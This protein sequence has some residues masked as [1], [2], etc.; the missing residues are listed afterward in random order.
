MFCSNCGAQIPDGSKF[1]GECGA[2]IENEPIAQQQSAQSETEIQP[3]PQTQPGTQIQPDLQPVQSLPTQQ[4]MGQPAPKK[5]MP[6]WAKV[7]IGVGIGIVALFI[8]FIVLIFVLASFA[9]DKKATDSKAENTTVEA[10]SAPEAQKEEEK[11]EETVPEQNTDEAEDKPLYGDPGIEEQVIYDEGGVKVTATGFSADKATGH[12]LIDIKLE[13]NSGQELLITN[14][15]TR[16]NGIEMDGAFYCRAENGQTY[17]EKFALTGP[18]LKDKGIDRIET[19]EFSL[20]GCDNDY[21]DVFT[22]PSLMIKT[23]LAGDVSGAEDKKDQTEEDQDWTVKGEVKFKYYGYYLDGNIVRIE[24]DDMASWYV[25][26]KEDGSGY[27]YLGDD[28]QGDLGGWEGMG[29]D[30]VMKAGISV[31]EDGSFLK[32]GALGLDFDGNIL[33]FLSDDA[34]LEKLHPITLD[35][36]KKMKE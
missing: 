11:V 4:Q 31:F 23:D 16:V 7:L 5:G 34:D 1:C 15:G 29:D 2:R 20:T 18:T 17:E 24:D 32:D 14:D 10:Q 30:F 6:A 26:L 13:N 21:N 25:T 22:T 36:Y 12:V 8:I 9:P 33:V 19:I 28:N 35:E 3:E 27:L